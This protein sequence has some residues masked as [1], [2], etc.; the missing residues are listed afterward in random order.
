[1]DSSSINSVISGTWYDKYQTGQFQMNV[2]AATD[3]I[4]KGSSAERD[5]RRPDDRRLA[6]GLYEDRDVG[7]IVR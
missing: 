1:M 7:G 3:G 5:G 4:L 2:G 6:H